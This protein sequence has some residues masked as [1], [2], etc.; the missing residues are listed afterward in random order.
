MD[1]QQTTSTLD[2]NDANLNN[3]IR[4]RDELQTALIQQT[5]ARWWINIYSAHGHDVQYRSYCGD[6]NW[7]TPS[8]L[9]DELTKT[10]IESVANGMI[11][12]WLRRK[13]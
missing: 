3:I 10:S 7:F 8:L 1:R 4:F 12:A 6:F 5:G 9:V 2:I 11:Q 13:R